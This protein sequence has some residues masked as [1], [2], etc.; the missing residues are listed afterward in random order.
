MLH[1]TGNKIH[2]TRGDTAFIKVDLKKHDGETYVPQEGDHIYFRLKKLATANN[3]LVEKEVSFDVVGNDTYLILELQENDT[4]DL[5]FSTYKYEI[6]VVTSEGYR[7]TAIE[8][9]AFEI[10]AEL[11]VHSG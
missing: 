10:G 7:F 1:I 2:L 3:V 11:E 4:K 5:D 6:E 8:N 9:T